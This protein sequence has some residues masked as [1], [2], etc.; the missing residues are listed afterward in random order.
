MGSLEA[1]HLTR[2]RYKSQDWLLEPLISF[3]SPPQ[4]T[5]MK[6]TFHPLSLL[7]LPI[8]LTHQQHLLSHQH[9]LQASKHHGQLQLAQ[10]AM[11]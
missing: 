1:L 2:T 10:M 8:S 9:L 5:L 3:K 6:V 11:Q 7:Y 4:M